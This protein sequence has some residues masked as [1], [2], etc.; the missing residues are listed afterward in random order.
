MTF[1]FIQT[2]RFTLRMVTPQ[3]YNHAME[4]FSDDELMA[5]FGLDEH[6]LEKQKS[7]QAG[8]L[9]TFNKSFLNF[10]P[11]DKSSG[12]VIGWCGYH[13]WY[14]NHNRAEV[15]YHLNADEHKRKGYMTE[16]LDAVLRYG[17]DV[18]HL[19][20]V[21]ALTATYNI[22]SIKTLEKFGFTHE[23]T[24][25]EHYFVDGI[26]EDSLLYSLLKSEFKF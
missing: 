23:G 18:M 26:P 11:I 17:F 13:T 16:I 3:V 20:R 8:G 10:Y 22:A 19:H 6:G 24:L 5:F 2:P 4:N 9:T 25:R 15:G 21:E 12:K 7:R 14:T 1:D